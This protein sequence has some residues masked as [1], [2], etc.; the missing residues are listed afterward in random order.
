MVNVLEVIP[1]KDCTITV[2][3]LG[4]LDAENVRG[5]L[6]AAVSEGRSGGG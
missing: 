5:R 2:A 3:A 1:G 4:P 6:P